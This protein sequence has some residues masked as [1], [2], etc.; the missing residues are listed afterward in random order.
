MLASR[1]VLSVTVSY[2]PMSESVPDSLIKRNMLFC[3]LKRKHC[4]LLGPLRCQTVFNKGPERVPFLVFLFHW[5]YWSYWNDSAVLSI[6]ILTPLCL[7]RTLC[8]FCMSCMDIVTTCLLKFDIYDGTLRSCDVTMDI[9]SQLRG[10]SCTPHEPECPQTQKNIYTTL[11]DTEELKD[12]QNAKEKWY[13]K[14][15]WRWD[16]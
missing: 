15:G 13:S 6:K 3:W 1:Q 5:S 12:F 16:I 14:I 10:S 9:G 11:T 2:V 8:S 4:A 7:N